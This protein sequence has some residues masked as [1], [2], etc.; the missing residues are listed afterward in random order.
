M[1]KGRSRP[2][3]HAAKK[4]DKVDVTPGRHLQVTP[5]APRFGAALAFVWL[6]LAAL[7]APSAAQPVVAVA[8]RTETRGDATRLIVDL[9]A[10]VPVKAYVLADPDRVVVDLPEVNF[11]IE[12]E[13][14]RRKP[15][16]DGSLIRAFRG[17]LLA[18]GRSRI[19][20][21]LAGP[22][23]VAA[24]SV[25]KIA[26]GEPARLVV[27]LV[28]A[29][30]ASF[31][32]AVAA[33][34][35]EAARPAPAMQAVVAANPAGKLVVVLDPGHGGVDSGASQGADIV[36]KTIVFDFARAMAAQLETTGRFKVILTRNSDVF[37]ALAERV[38]MA[39]EANA[40][41]FVSLH[42]DMLADGADVQGA[43]FYTGADKASDVEAARLAEKENR[44]DIAA[45]A[46]SPED[47]SGVSDILADL[48]RRETRTYSHLFARTLAGVW[49]NAG[50]LNKNPQ[51]SA[52]FRVLKASD[53]PSVLIELGYLSSARDAAN[54]ASPVWRAKAAAVAADA[55]DRFFDS[56]RIAGEAAPAPAGQPSDGAATV[57]ESL[58]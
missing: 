38:R 9:S 39:R 31:A 30:R 42:A 32:A 1:A 53:V 14:A 2:Q 13:G 48:T 55:V 58:H 46:E 45:G 19:V 44:A 27:E 54:L 47:A 7:C 33:G 43:T 22:A 29:D 50:R 35:G 57:A 3:R 15:E 26:T 11:Q 21:D 34:R 12:G 37:V 41:L 40:A 25:E 51:R 17:G 56:R 16:P 10:S 49:Q 52:G 24:A 5:R 8:A 6:A 20:I 4:M 36:E 23:R 28:R 18:P